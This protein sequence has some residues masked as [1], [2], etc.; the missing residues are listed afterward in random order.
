MADAT[1]SFT[2]QEV[3]ATRRN[4]VRRGKL[5][6]NAGDYVTGGITL[7]LS[8]ATNSA[9]AYGRFT[10][11]PDAVRVIQQ[12]KKYLIQIIP[13]TLLTNWKVHIAFTGTGDS[14]PFNEHGVA[15]IN[16]ALTDDSSNIKLEF[17]TQK[18]H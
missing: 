11:T 17:I 14:A 2:V 18:G 15:A 13:G 5:V 7:D 16:S 6:I 4:I 1:A 9:G 12:P 10:R 3:D 8:T